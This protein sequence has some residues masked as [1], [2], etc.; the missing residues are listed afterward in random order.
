MSQVTKLKGLCF[1]QCLPAEEDQKKSRSSA[2]SA[3]MYLVI[4]SPPVVDTISAWPVSMNT[5]IADT[6]ISV[7]YARRDS[8]EDLT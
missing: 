1:Q 3:W 4:Q 5:G 2:L 8:P 7:H 6:S